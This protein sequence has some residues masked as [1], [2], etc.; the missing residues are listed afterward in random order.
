MQL[1]DPVTGEARRAHL[2]V[3]CL[4]FSRCAFV[5][6]TQ[7]MKQ[8]GVSE[9]LGDEVDSPLPTPHALGSVSVVPECY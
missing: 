5:W 6:P 2:F 4:Q 8:D 9:A 3:A 7:D 1:T